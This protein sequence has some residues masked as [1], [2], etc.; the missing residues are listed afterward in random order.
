MVYPLQYL[1]LP[2]NCQAVWCTITVSQK[3]DLR[4]YLTF[5]PIQMI[6]L[7][8]ILLIIILIMYNNNLM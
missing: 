4:L 5:I 8:R 3:L 1:Y 6:K 2:P 7:I